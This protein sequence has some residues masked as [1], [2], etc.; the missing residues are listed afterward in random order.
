MKFTSHRVSKIGEKHSAL[1]N[2]HQ[3]VPPG[4]KSFWPRQYTRFCTAT[5]NFMKLSFR[6]RKLESYEVCVLPEL[7]SERERGYVV[8]G[9]ESS[10]MC[11]MGAISTFLGHGRFSM[12]I[13][14]IITFWKISPKINWGILTSVLHLDICQIPTV[15]T[16]GGDDRRGQKFWGVLPNVL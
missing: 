8:F 14:K 15:P 11:L 5:V 2:S 10:Y 13:V 1:R 12:Q 9:R 7:L 3:I 16:G 4:E 6:L